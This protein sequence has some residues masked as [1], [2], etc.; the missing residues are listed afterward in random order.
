M[1]RTKMTQEQKYLSYVAE[2]REKHDKELERIKIQYD[3]EL[4]AV[5][6]RTRW[7]EEEA[8]EWKARWESAVI[9]GDLLRT[10]NEELQ[11]RVEEAESDYQDFCELTKE[12]WLMTEP[13]FF[14]NI[15][16]L[17]DYNRFKNHIGVGLL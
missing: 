6:T 12:V 1:A 5:K 3:A 16:E 15:F 7:N 17:D 13:G 4:E 8:K 9:D 10:K 14:A 11:E 2:L